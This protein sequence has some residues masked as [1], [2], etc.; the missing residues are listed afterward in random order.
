MAFIAALALPMLSPVIEPEVS[1]TSVTLIGG[2][3]A[4]GGAWTPTTRKYSPG[5]TP[6]ATWVVTVSLPVFCEGKVTL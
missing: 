2:G 6:G 4:A 3:A 5:S 1:A